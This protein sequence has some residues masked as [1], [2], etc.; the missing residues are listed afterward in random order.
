MHPFEILVPGGLSAPALLR[1]G[2]VD[3]A[4]SLPGLDPPWALLL[5]RGAPLVWLRLGFLPCPGYPLYALSIL[6]IVLCPFLGSSPSY[7]PCGWVLPLQIHTP[8]LACTA[9]AGFQLCSALFAWVM[10]W[11]MRVGLYGVFGLPCPFLS[12]SS[13]QDPFCLLP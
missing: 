4:V 12:A 1:E 6:S 2:L 3:L 9:P 7:P 13:H 11:G 5:G 10:A 8:G